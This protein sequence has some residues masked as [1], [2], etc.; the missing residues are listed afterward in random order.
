MEISIIAIFLGL[1]NVPLHCFPPPSSSSPP[2]Q[3]QLYPGVDMVL[4]TFALIRHRCPHPPLSV[5]QGLM[6]KCV[7]RQ[8]VH[9]GCFLLVHC[10]YAY[11]IHL[12]GCKV[13]TS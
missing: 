6:P 7:Q 1:A 3:T 10:M 13:G 9:N 11:N 12:N 8:K 2:G 4:D 5:P